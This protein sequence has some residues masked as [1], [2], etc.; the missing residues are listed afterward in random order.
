MNAIE[1]KFTFD[2]TLNFQQIFI[3]ADMYRG[4]GNWKKTHYVWKLFLQLK[5][6][7]VKTYLIRG[8]EENYYQIINLESNAC[9]NIFLR[10]CNIKSLR[11]WFAR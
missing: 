2:K 8:L 4:V 11:V 3:L 10:I 1:E 7:C 5:L 6:K 9:D